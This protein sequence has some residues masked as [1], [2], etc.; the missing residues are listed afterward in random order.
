MLKFTRLTY[1]RYEGHVAIVLRSSSNR[2]RYVSGI[3][4][5]KLDLLTK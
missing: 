1:A 3:I 2:S 4:K 5:P